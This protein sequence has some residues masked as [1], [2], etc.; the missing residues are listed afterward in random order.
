MHALFL[1]HPAHTVTNGFLFLFRWSLPLVFRRIS[2]LIFHNFYL[3]MWCLLFLNRFLLSVGHVIW[4]GLVEKFMT[5]EF[6][7]IAIFISVE[8]KLKVIRFLFVSQFRLKTIEK[9]T[10]TTKR[11]ENELHSTATKFQNE[12]EKMKK[13]KIKSRG[14][15]VMC[16]CFI[17]RDDRL[18]ILHIYTHMQ[19]MRKRASQTT[20]RDWVSE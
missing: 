7:R 4:T 19:I 20:Q 18:D 1:F 3:Q 11:N 17:M 12:N 14:Y 8:E 9:K 6:I 5:I 15:S 2:N 13:S 16:M 10:T